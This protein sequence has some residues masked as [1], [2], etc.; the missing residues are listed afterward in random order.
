MPHVRVAS[1]AVAFLLALAPAAWERR[2]AAPD[3]GQWL[4]QQVL[5]MDWEALRARGLS[6][7]KEAFWTPDE[8]GVLT[9]AVQIGGCSASF[10]SPD[11][12]VLTNHHCGYG[13]VQELSTPE[14]NRLENGYAATTPAEELPAPGMFVLVVRRI[15]DV[16]ERIHAAAA[17][18][19][20]PAERTDLVEG[21]I[22]R[23][24]AEGQKEPNTVCS[25]A[26]FLNGAQYHLYYRTR[27]D[28]VRLVYAPSRAVGE[29]GG[30]DDNW[31]WPRH[32]GDFMFFRAY[33]A[34]DGSP[35]KHHAENV[36][37]RPKHWLKTA[38]QGVKDGDL[39]MVLGYP[40]RTERYLTS[41]GVAARQEL[42]YPLRQKMLERFIRTL[43][44]ASKESA[45]KAL[46][47]STPIKSLANVEKNAR[48][49]I[50]GLAKNETVARKL[51]E[52]R[53]FSRWLAEAPERA[54]EHGDVLAEMMALERDMAAWT[55]R[56]V[57][58]SGFSNSALT[59]L[60]AASSAVDA[61]AA[62]RR[63]SGAP[64]SE[65]R[66]K[67]RKHLASDEPMEDWAT[68]QLPLL[69]YVVDLARSL[70]PDERPRGVE[71][72]L[73]LDGEA[74]IQKA[75]SSSK[76]LKGEARAALLDLDAAAIAASDDPLTAL[77]AG[78]AAERKA[79]AGRRREFTGRQLDVGRR[80]IA[81]QQA[82][83]G[84]TFYPDANSTLR[85][86]TATVRGY[87]PKDGVWFTPQTTVRGLLDKHVDAEPFDAPDALIAAAAKRRESRFFD[88]ELG[89]V[90]MCFLS[91]ADTTGGN[92]GSCV[93]NGAG[94]LVGVNFDRVFHNVAG[95]F[96]WSPERSRNVVCDVRFMLWHMESVIPCPRLVA[97]LG[98]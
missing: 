51:D 80:W 68:V 5:D 54:K 95:D 78:F 82:W 35:R 23:L 86:S 43:Q 1:F 73:A 13:A 70:P 10:V 49:M 18:A 21:A 74:A 24:V 56:D 90:P 96:G 59:L 58:L 20:S 77:A 33:A 30:D 72:F 57:V 22:R 14:N 45:A 93:V 9:A 12:L 27:L 98:G 44:E 64:D 53:A 41:V 26:S 40:G 42:L 89:D 47:L 76:L 46:E 29:Y 31:E 32:T 7:S 50:W 65:A 75:L 55:R 36:P 25:V 60:A 62:Q 6:L 88:G 37:Y 34:P 19:K 61:A 15:E 92:S 66:A 8:G 52:E 16:T 2:R 11:G 4:P 83:R 48:G 38:K 69:A 67:L 85:V 17:E 84:R 71:P 81:A 28:D 94:E 79:A 39:V 87:A 3:E 63:A 91:D 97:E